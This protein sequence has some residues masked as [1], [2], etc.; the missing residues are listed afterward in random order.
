M[1]KILV[2]T[3]FSD[4]A[5]HAMEYA[6]AFGDVDAHYVLMNSYESPN[7]GG[8][9]AFISMEEILEKEAKKDLKREEVRIK[10]EHPDLSFECY[11]I[12]GSIETGIN[13]VRSR[14][15]IDFLVMG[16]QGAT[17]MKEFV[18]GS[19]TQHVLENYMH[20]MIAVPEN[21]E[22]KGIKNIVFAADFHK[23]KNDDSLLPLVSIAK[24]FQAHIHVVHI[25]EGTKDLGANTNENMEHLKEILSNVSYSTHVIQGEEIAASLHNYA[26]KV[27]ADMTVLMPRNLSFFNKLF[28]SQVS[29]DMAYHAT[30]PLLILHDVK[31]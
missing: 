21:F 15:E 13:R 14:L 7:V 22:F 17:G 23:L 1:K 2:P 18:F 27:S 5:R 24:K 31:S 4:N 20:P 30:R 10:K 3:D 29:K 25:S 12:Y 8:S 9:G 28:T 11:P 19:N 6:I 16:T 26:E